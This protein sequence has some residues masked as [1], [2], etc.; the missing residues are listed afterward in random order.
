MTARA[1]GR[2]F[3]AP[4]PGAGAPSPPARVPAA[5]LLA[6]TAILI[7]TLTPSAHE[8]A[9]GWDGCMLCGTRGTADALL[10]LALFVPLGAAL[11]RRRAGGWRAVALGAALSAAVEAAQLLIP[12]R[13]PSP[14]DLLFNTV[15]AAA[16]YAA[17]LRAGTIL[18]P[19]PR[20]AAW[21]ALA[22]SVLVAGVVAGT[23]WAAAPAPPPGPYIGQWTPET[24]DYPRLPGRVL[25]ARIGSVRI[26]QGR[27]GADAEV[28]RALRGAG[29][30]TVRWIVGPRIDAPAPLLRIVGREGTE[31]AAVFIRRE[32]LIVVRRTRAGGMRLDQPLL[33]GPDVIRGAAPGDTV[34]LRIGFHGRGAEMRTD[35]GWRAR[36][37]IG[38]GR[39][40]VLLMSRM[41]ADGIPWMDAAWLALWVL[42]LGLWLPRVFNGWR[43][44]RAAGARR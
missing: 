17:G 4:S 43:S 22:W 35:H 8:G 16:G 6:I 38:P 15:G 19:S 11:A 1:P 39:G 27:L 42:P 28:R 41:D 21:L 40:W 14:P 5:V 34:T 33:F 7:A 20:G 2:P 44:R 24:G 13:D 25:E 37:A 3:R 30:L 26:P 9:A 36:D 32:R 29:P 18:R 10:N 31:A 12:G 23:A